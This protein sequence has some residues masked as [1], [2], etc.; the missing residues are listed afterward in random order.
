[1]ALHVAGRAIHTASLV[2]A[3]VRLSLLHLLLNQVREVAT[4]V[5]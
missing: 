3:L 4:Y 1:M 5:R 2:P